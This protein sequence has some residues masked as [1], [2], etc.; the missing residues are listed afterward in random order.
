MTIYIDVVLFENLI[1]NYIILFTTSQ[2]LKIKQKH[3][4]LILSS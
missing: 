2:I 1:M 4:R 3:I